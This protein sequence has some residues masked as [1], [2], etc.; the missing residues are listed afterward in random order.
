MLVAEILSR[1]SA[2]ERILEERQ[3]SSICCFQ[4]TPLGSTGSPAALRRQLGWFSAGASGFISRW[5]PAANLRTH[6][7]IGMQGT[8]SKFKMMEEPYTL[9]SKILQPYVVGLNLTK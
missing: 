5:S 2:S 8:H 1:E 4:A 7:G 6:A 3:S 9:D